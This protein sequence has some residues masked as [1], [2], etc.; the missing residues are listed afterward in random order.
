MQSTPTAGVSRVG[1]AQAGSCQNTG[2]FPPKRKK[3]NT[4]HKLR[5]C[6]MSIGVNSSYSAYLSGMPSAP[7]YG[8]ASLRARSARRARF[9]SAAADH[10]TQPDSPHHH[11][12]GRLVQTPAHQRIEH[13]DSW[14]CGGGWARRATWVQ[15][16]SWTARAAQPTR[17]AAPPVAFRGQRCQAD[18]V[19]PATIP[20]PPPG[21]V[22]SKEHI[23]TVQNGR[24]L[25]ESV[26]T[27]HVYG[28]IL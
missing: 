4:K 24:P 12:Q 7:C 27:V 15:T 10:R 5:L 23:R 17:P 18:H 1:T 11:H 9:S 21:G 6:R 20:R 26:C 14:E 25:T 19:H 2:F 16:T 8:A 13:Y 28:R 3:Q 22:P